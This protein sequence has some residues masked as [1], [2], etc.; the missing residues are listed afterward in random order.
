MNSICNVL[1][2]NFYILVIICL[3]CI[4]ILLIS[5]CDKYIVV[6]I[7]SAI[8]IIILGLSL[9]RYK[10][11]KKENLTFCEFIGGIIDI[12]SG[13]LDIS[14]FEKQKTRK[15]MFPTPAGEVGI[16]IEDK[17]K[18]DNELKI[19]EESIKEDENKGIVIRF[20]EYLFPPA[21]KKNLKDIIRK[22]I[23][24]PKKT[25][26]YNINYNV[27]NNIN[28]IDDEDDIIAELYLYP[29]ITHSKPPS[30]K[31][32]IPSSS[33]KSNP[34]SN[35]NLSIDNFTQKFLINSKQI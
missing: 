21:P 16:D 29:E 6:G 19:Q 28:N 23:I 18:L 32:I 31:K 9:I 17:E 24:I 10:Y 15:V 8:Y 20:I 11:F 7:S 22:N 14:D 33:N 30:S 13:S 25:K 35:K 1:L 27:N 3:I 26:D 4:I 5:N 12:K 34:F 2:F